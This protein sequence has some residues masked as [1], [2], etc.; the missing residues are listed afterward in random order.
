MQKLRKSYL[1]LLICSL[2]L[3]TSCSN[4][5]NQLP[6][7]TGKTA[8]LI[9]V[10]EN[11]QSSSVTLESIKRYFGSPQFGLNQPEPMANVI[12]IYKS[13][14]EGLLSMH[15][16]VLM[17]QIS[18]ECVNPELT[19]RSD[20]WASPQIAVS[21]KASSDT[22]LKSL[23]IKNSEKIYQFFHQNDI[24]RVINAF[25]RDKSNS[26]IDTIKKVFGIDMVVPLNYY[27]AKQTKNFIWLRKEAKEFSQSIFIYSF[28]Y[29]DTIQLNYKTIY[30]KRDTITKK[31]IQGS[32]ENSYM[33]I[34]NRYIKPQSINIK[35]KD[36]YAIETRGLWKVVNDF[37]GGP[38]INFTILDEKNN[39]IIVAD[40]YVYA[41]NL[42]KRDYLI[43]I[44]AI[45]HSIK[46]L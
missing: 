29:T 46:F 21:L 14:F 25:S 43:Q 32:L 23:F 20:V 35:F 40:G 44:E 30:S 26:V 15:R 39:R 42:E 19:A 18:P 31:F 33:A 10:K 17:L 6:S 16:N 3:L 27:L 1:T 9:L 37:M 11:V 34:E 8:E 24:R 2:I 45:I 12:E 38:F 13:A 22:A 28:P 7:S 36:N 5:K 41:P 4:Q